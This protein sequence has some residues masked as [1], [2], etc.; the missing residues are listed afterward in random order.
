MPNAKKIL[1][2]A[3]KLDAAPAFETDAEQMFWL[4][5]NM[6]HEQFSD[7][8]AAMQV[9]RLAIEL[10]ALTNGERE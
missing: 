6:G 1:E 4:R 5:C 3:L 8:D 7:V 2:L 9:W 10:S